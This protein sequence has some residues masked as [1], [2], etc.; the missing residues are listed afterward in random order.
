[1]SA[2]ARPAPETGGRG[3]GRTGW[4]AVR[5]A[6]TTQRGPGAPPALKSVTVTV[7]LPSGQKIEGRLRRI[8]DFLVSLYLP[9]GSERTI[10][11]HGVTP[12]VALHDPLKPH[13]DLLPVY[14]DKEIHD[15]TAFLVTLK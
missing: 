8:D 4:R 15:V 11:R 2:G 12:T 1:M 14:T 13:R 5:G 9:D 7:T 3:W 6:I 10:A